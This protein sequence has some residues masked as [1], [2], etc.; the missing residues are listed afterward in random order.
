[1]AVLTLAIGIGATTAIFSAVNALILRPL[2]YTQPDELMGVTLITPSRDGRA[3]NDQMVW[4]YPKYQ[5]FGDAQH[6]FSELALYAGA[7]FTLST[8]EVEQVR[9]ETVG[10]RYLATLGLAPSR[11]RDFDPAIDAGPGAPRQVLLSEALWQRRFNADPAVIGRTIEIDRAPYEVLGVAPHR[12]LGLTGQADVF[13]PITTRSAEDLSQAQSHEFNVV[14]RRRPGIGVER[15]RSETQGI[16]ARVNEA[17]PDSRFGGVWSATARPLDDAR[18]T[19]MLKRSLYILFGAVALVLLIACVNVAN[20][21]LGR[22]SARRR[23][24]AVRL[25]IGAGRGRLVR[26]LLT[27]SLVLSAIGGAASV[28]V[29]LWGT[30]ALSGVNPATSLRVQRS[31]EFAAVGFT[32]IHLDG[33][34]LLFTFA[35]TL[36]VGIVFGLWPALAATRTSLSDALKGGGADARRGAVRRWIGG[37]RLLV[38]TEVAL[39]LVLLAGSGL[40]IRSLIKLLSVDVGFTARNVLTLRLTVPPGGMGRDS[41]PAFYEQLLHRVSTL[42]GVSAAG[43]ANCPP[44]N[45]GC[46]VTIITFMDREK[47][48]LAR[49]PQIGAHWTSPDWFKTIGVPL[50]RG[51]YFTDA[52]RM[53]AP[54]VV[55]INEMAAAKF[56]PNEDPIGKRVGIM[57]GGFADG[58]EVVGIVGNVRQTAD[59]AARPDVY[60]SYFQSPRPNMMI[61]VKGTTSAASLGPDVR[62]AIREVAP[63]FPVYDMKPL[64]ERAASATAPA[65]FSAVLLG[66][67]AAVALSLA[68]IG[69]YGV[70]SLAVAQRTREIGIRMALGADRQTVMRL[71]VG[72][73]VALAAAGGVAGL[74]A[75]LVFTRVLRAQLFDVT[76]SDPVT[77]ASIALLLGGAAVVASWIPARRATRVHPTEAL[78]EG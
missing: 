31:G 66:L 76:P 69:I 9:G 58:A 23:E 67:F 61:F 2:P 29:A 41:L 47:A 53:G 10:A 26:L 3:G 59:S 36:V 65:R 28:L 14:A 52:D 6:A 20:L 72:E 13:I 21:L 50:R 64:A 17:F 60:L 32:S 7:Q 37:R 68:V 35:L 62:R 75:A 54:K 4:S 63:R 19:P 38:M 39:A 49:A 44:L 1:V 11:G 42:A 8:G 24:I 48:D 30:R 25:A 43:I 12:F 57:Q 51:R 55:V 46:N 71:V 18:V 34:A 22:A 27:E 45:G 78:R 70:M 5:I 73:G 77:Y 33:A 15:A 40:M 56:W 16:G 74:L